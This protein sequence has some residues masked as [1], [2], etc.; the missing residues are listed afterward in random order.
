MPTNRTRRGRTRGDMDWGRMHEQHYGPGSSLLAGCGYYMFG[1]NFTNRAIANRSN[2]RG[3]E[4]GFYWQLR[5]D[6]QAR[7]IEFMRA[8]WLLHHD[9]IMAA[10]NNRDEHERYLASEHRAD[11]AEPWALTEFGAP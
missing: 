8:D 11:P 2:V 1:Q 7:V 3:D 10:W 5:P 4:H 9:A 6:N